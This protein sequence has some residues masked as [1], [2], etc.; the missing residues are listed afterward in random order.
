[1]HKFILHNWS[2][3]AVADYD[4]AAKLSVAASIPKNLQRRLSPLARVVMQAI[5]GCLGLN[6]TMPAVFSSS[7]GE[8][9]RALSMLQGLQAGEALSPTAFS[10]SVH[11]A[12]AGLYSM[13]YH[14]QHE[15]SVLAPCTEGIAAAFIEGLGLLQEGHSEVL[16]V[17]YDEALDAFYPTQPYRLSAPGLLALAVRISLTGPGTQFSL[18]LINERADSPVLEHIGQLNAWWRFLQDQRSTDLRLSN[19]RHSWQWCKQC[20]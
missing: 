18:K 16:L 5:V 3:C 4:E 12:I 14:N 6:S 17:W 8:V 20:A 11:N 9:N 13:A 19:T 15:I 2:A 10:L 1:M 7:H